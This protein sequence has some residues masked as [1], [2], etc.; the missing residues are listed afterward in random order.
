[1][2]KGHHEGLIDYSTFQKIQDRLNKPKVPVRKNVAH[3]FPLRGFVTCDDCGTIFT[4]CWSRGRTK[5]YAYYHCPTK[6]CPSYGKSIRRERLEGEFETILEELQPSK[7][8][9]ETTYAMFNRLW[10]MQ[11]VVAK[12]RIK[13]MQAEC[14][15]IDKQIA[16]LM[17]RIVEASSH[18]VISAYEQ[19]IGKLEQDKL[20]LNERIVQ[21]GKPQSPF[22]DSFRTAFEF[23]KS[24]VRLWR[25][26]N[27]GAQKTVLKLTFGERLAYRRIEGF[28]T[29]VP[30]LP[31]QVIQGFKG[32]REGNFKLENQMAHP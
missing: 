23:L 14:A 21:A 25:S 16:G 2:R 11:G 22:E 29:A 5:K 10:D 12:E 7:P 24:P 28:R 19:R 18:S 27:F 3:D 20:I 9:F 13:E 1:M 8:V 26:G 6:G 15:R 4:S 32:S 17:E 30:S 31:F